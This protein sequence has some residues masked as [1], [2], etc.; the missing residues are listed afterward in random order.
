MTSD[1]LFEFLFQHYEMVVK[2]KRIDLSALTWKLNPTQQ[3]HFEALVLLGFMYYNGMITGSGLLI[4]LNDC[5]NL[6]L[7]LQ[8]VC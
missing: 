3:L 7:P 2:F 5:R 4:V 8:P 1:S 6:I